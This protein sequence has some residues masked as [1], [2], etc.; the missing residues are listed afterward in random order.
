VLVPGERLLRLN[1][2]A[3]G[4]LEWLALSYYDLKQY[5]DCIRVCETMLDM[6]LELEP[7]YY[8]EARA[9]AKLKD[10][11]QSDTLL[12]KALE[13]AISPTAEWY[14][15]DLGDNLESQKEYRRSIAHYDTA[16]YLFK[17]PLT[18]YACGRIAE[19]EL[20]DPAAA[21]R[22]YRRYLAVA[23]PK[24]EEE[25]KAYGYVKRRWGR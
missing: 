23:K 1:E 10:Y 22:Y 19:T 25:K 8:Y 21:R 11:A 6:G 14:Y 20:H 13:K 16:Y 3:V 2:P 7:V 18:L 15:D 4:P 5:S 12:R 24:T 9:E 17:D